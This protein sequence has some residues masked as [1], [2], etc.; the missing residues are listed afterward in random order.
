M[1]HR[2]KD[3]ILPLSLFLLTILT[4]VPFTSKL[5]YHW[6]SVQFALALENYDITVHQPHPPGYFLYVMLGRLVNFFVKDANSTFI[7]I[8]ILFS[9]LTIV[10]I[11]FLGKEIFDNKTGILAALIAL[12]SPN[13]WFHGEVALTYVVEAFFSSFVALLCWRILKGEHKYLWLSVVAL[14]I[15]GG[16]RQNTV[17]FL[18]P[19]WLFSVKG[20]PLRKII[21]S[22]GLLG[23]ICLLWFIPMVWMTGGWN[24][25]QSAFRELW[26]FNTGHVSV[27]EKGWGSFQIFSTALANFV[28]YGVGAGIFIL[29]IATYSLIRHR[30]LRFL[31]SN[32]IFFY[33]LWIMPSVLFYLLIF[34]HP[35]NPGYVLIFLP[36]L[37]LLTAASIGFISNDLKRLITKDFAPLFASAIIVVNAYLFFFSHYPASYAQIKNHDNNLSIMLEGIK[38]FNPEN[39][40]IFTY[41]DIFFSYRHVMYYLPEYRVYQP[42]LRIIGGLRKTFWCHNRRTFVTD[43]ITLPQEVKSFG[44]LLIAEDNKNIQTMKA[45][46]IRQVLPFIQ[47]AVGP[48]EKLQEVYPFLPIRSQKIS[49]NAML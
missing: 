21:T 32:K 48:I 3:I 6:D 36:A 10:A 34:I 29:G 47:I 27:F 20:V 28:L 38:T 33:L 13:L 23:I 30:K 14:G 42:E 41:A 39:T 2:N 4:R 45:L 31:D 18:L 9:G 19:L 1:A 46:S 5:L 8:S 26:L 40:V 12:T 35:A 7:F 43:V 15:A 49:G 37:L 17:V 24:A 16:I 22:V 25:Y 44:I 11:Y